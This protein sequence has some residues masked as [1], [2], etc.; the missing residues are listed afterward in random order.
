MDS[1][2]LARTARRWNSQGHGEITE[3]PQI[4][5]K[6]FS[7]GEC[8]WCECRSG[9]SFIPNIIPKDFSSKHREQT[10]AVNTFRHLEPSSHV[11][12]FVFTTCICVFYRETLQ[13]VSSF[14]ILSR[15]G[16]L[17]CVR[18]DCASIESMLFRLEKCFFG[19]HNFT[20]TFL[21]AHC[22]L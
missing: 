16:Q 9:L 12:A 18:L 14:T 21:S 7:P 22:H 17:M 6:E 2:C 19:F 10:G 3:S 1:V 15:F 8:V 13:H 5:A 11:V 4:A 20:C